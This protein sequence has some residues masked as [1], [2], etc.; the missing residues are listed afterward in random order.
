MELCKR[1]V[2]TEVSLAAD[3]TGEIFAD[4]ECRD[5]FQQMVLGIEYR[6]CFLNFVFFYHSS[7]FVA[8]YFFSEQ[9][10]SVFFS[11]LIYSFF[12]VLA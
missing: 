9:G 11:H 1:G 6:K 4:D 12:F 3:K 7:C 2:L 8:R 10:S 5:V